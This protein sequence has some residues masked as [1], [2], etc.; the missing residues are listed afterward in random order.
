M[1][2]TAG[3]PLDRF[4]VLHTNDFHNRLAPEQAQKLRRLRQEVGPQGMLLDAGDAVAAGNI[5][6]HPGGE[7]ILEQMSWIGYDAMTVGNREFHFTPAGFRCKLSRA[8]FPI[9]CANVRNSR[10]VAF[11]ELRLDNATK[12]DAGNVTAELFAAP[13][14]PVRPFVV[15]EATPGWRVVVFGLTVPMITERMLVRKVS[16]YVFDDPIQTAERLVPF[17]RRKYTPDILVALTHIGLQQDR[18]L[19]AAVP[20]IDLIVGGHTHNVID[21]GEPV[22]ETW[23]VQAGSH[24][25]YI[26]KVEIQYS[27]GAGAKWHMNARL[28]AL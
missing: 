10:T 2:K 6:F 20:G 3:V 23:I 15:H 12:A 25:H 27:R 24:G 9:L 1:K 13:D 7:P 22:G 21:A 28:E 16:A 11:D 18:T 26:G 4:T 8:S 17:L 14:L 5:T 19:A